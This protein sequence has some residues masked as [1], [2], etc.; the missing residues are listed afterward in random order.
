MPALYFQTTSWS[1]SWTIFNQTKL[2]LT[3]WATLENKYI[4]HAN[5]NQILTTEWNINL[6][7]LSKYACWSSYF[8]S[9]LKSYQLWEAGRRTLVHWSILSMR[10]Y[11]RAQ[12]EN[13]LVLCNWTNN[14][15]ILYQF[16]FSCKKMWHKTNRP[17]SAAKAFRSPA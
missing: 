12:Q 17:H 1:T 2:L 13:L 5:T 15:M 10:S 11:L 8:L 9:I 3:D 4:V 14:I 7:Q 6:R 16:P